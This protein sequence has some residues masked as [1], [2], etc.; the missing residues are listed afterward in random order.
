MLNESAKNI[1]KEIRVL[2]EKESNNLARFEQRMAALADQYGDQVYAPLFFITAHLEVSARTAKK[3]YFQLLSHW[4]VMNT[5]LT[6]EI[7]FRVAL[8]DYFV[9]INKRIK[10]PKIIEIKIFEKTQQ[11]SYIDELTQLY[12]YRYFMTLLEQELSRAKRYHAPLSLVIFDVD[13]FKYYNDNNGHLAGNKALKQL[14]RLVSKSIRDV[15]I[16][17]RFGGEEFALLLPETNKEGAMIIA[18]RICKA[19]RSAKFTY[20]SKQPLKC[21]SVSGG[22]A[23]FLVDAVTTEDLMRFADQALYRAKDWGKN[24]IALY[25]EERRDSERLATSLPGQIKLEK[26]LGDIILVEN[27]SEGGLLF[28][29]HEPLALGS[30]AHLYFDLP[31]RRNQIHCKVKA[32]RVEEVSAQEKYKIGVSILQMTQAE[33]NAIK[34]F[35]QGLQKVTP[36]K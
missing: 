21:F 24:Q 26:N 10:N 4:H 5:C 16:L 13:D 31:G 35:M 15:D 2:L 25:V 11:D 22:L 30:I 1:L 19:V 12:N 32:R 23:T 17:A 8:L 20:A 3:Y 18:N 14:A 27:I 6:R 33:Q 7:D 29:Y 28:N 34:K 36:K 9:S